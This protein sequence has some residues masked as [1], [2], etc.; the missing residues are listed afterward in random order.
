MKDGLYHREIYWPTE[1]DD[2]FSNHQIANIEFSKHVIENQGTADRRI[3]N[4]DE[5]TLDFIKA[6]QIFEI[7]LSKSKII[8]LVIRRKYKNKK[9]ICMAFAIK[10]KSLLCKTCWLNLQDDIHHTLDESKYIRGEEELPNCDK[11]S[12]SV[13]DLIKSKK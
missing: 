4:I 12:V 7:E 13:F 6:G 8:K 2:F 10:N 9:D 3:Y 1:F 5:I 11:M